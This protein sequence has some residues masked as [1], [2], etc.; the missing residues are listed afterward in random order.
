[1]AAKNFPAP[2]SPIEQPQIQPDPA[3]LLNELI[4]KGQGLDPKIAKS[5]LKQ[6]RSDR[7]R[8]RGKTAAAH[9]P[10]PGLPADS[11]AG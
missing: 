4:A 10:A 1:M 2:P 6:V 3:T 11:S 5:Y 7:K 9:D 8:W